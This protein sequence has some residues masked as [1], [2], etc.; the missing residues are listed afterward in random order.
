MKVRKSDCP[1]CLGSGTVFPPPIYKSKKCNH[2]VP[3][4]YLES[5]ILRNEEE[6][7]NSQFHIENLSVE[8]SECERLLSEY[9]SKGT[10]NE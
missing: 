8:V 10:E 7:K 3:K 6:I 4:I 9:F 2:D 1:F 5:K